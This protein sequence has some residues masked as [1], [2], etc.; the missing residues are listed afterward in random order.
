MKRRTKANRR[1]T[2]RGEREGK[3]KSEAE[4]RSIG[5]GGWGGGYHVMFDESSGSP[6]D[7]QRLAPF[8]QI[9]NMEE[10]GKG[11]KMRRSVQK[12]EEED[13]EEEEGLLD[14]NSSCN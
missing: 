3:T 12:T 10:V 1:R 5:G 4:G 13:E 14:R 6:T 9:S 11:Q 2:D 8:T 7:R